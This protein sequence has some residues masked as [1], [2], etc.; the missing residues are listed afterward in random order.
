MK[1]QEYRRLK[2]K[3]ARVRRKMALPSINKAV[4]LLSGAAR[5]YNSVANESDN[6]SEYVTPKNPTVRKDNGAASE[7]DETTEYVTPGVLRD[8]SKWK[9]YSE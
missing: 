8:D 4:A 3:V 9:G 7:S 6:M 1:K 2:K 5:K